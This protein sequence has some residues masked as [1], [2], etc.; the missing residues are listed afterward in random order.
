MS[1]YQRERR[2]KIDDDDYAEKICP[3]SLCK[4]RVDG[5]TNYVMRAWSP[6]EPKRIV[7]PTTKLICEKC[8][9]KLV[10]CSHNNRLCVEK[11]VATPGSVLITKTKNIDVCRKCLAV[12]LLDNHAEEILYQ[13]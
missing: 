1:K 9:N 2:F 11:P 3:C 4:E 5:Q 10:T 7:R 8:Y 12:Y 13:F 6:E